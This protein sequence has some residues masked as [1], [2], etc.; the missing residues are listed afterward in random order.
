VNAPFEDA[1]TPD[2]VES[3]DGLGALAAAENRRSSSLVLHNGVPELP[4]LL[5]MDMPSPR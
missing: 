5:G 1:S 3:D 4:E 2:T